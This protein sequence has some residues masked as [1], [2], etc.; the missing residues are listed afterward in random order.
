MQIWYVEIIV[1]KA[2]KT[3]FM[4]RRY[5]LFIYLFSNCRNLLIRRFGCFLYCS[6]YWIFNYSTLSIAHLWHK[7]LAD[8]TAISEARFCRYQ[9]EARR[10]NPPLSPR[11]AVTS[12]WATLCPSPAWQKS[13]YH[14]ISSHLIFSFY[15][16]YPAPFSTLPTSLK[17]ST[18]FSKK[19]NIFTRNEDF[20]CKAEG[21]L[22]SGREFPCV[23]SYLCGLVFKKKKKKCRSPSPG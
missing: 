8:L 9:A 10:T 2:L 19:K 21:S 20:N 12:L 11:G 23:S 5:N 15:S 3:I 16:F 22:F 6:V 1:K 7:L 14:L 13:M 4:T 18:R 17:M